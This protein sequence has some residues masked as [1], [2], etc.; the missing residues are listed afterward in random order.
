MKPPDVIFES[1]QRGTVSERRIVTLEN[2]G[3]G[4][5]TINDFE[6]TGTGAAHFAIDNDLLDR[7]CAEDETLSAS[8]SCL[9]GV[10]FTPSDAGARQAELTFTTNDPATPSAS[11]TLHGIAT[12]PPP[13]TPPPPASATP[14]GDTDGDGVMDSVDSCPGVPGVLSNGCP[15]DRDGD[16]IVDS[17]DACLTVAGSL[18]NG[19]PR[20]SDGDDVLDNEDRCI[21]VAGNLKNGCPN[22]L[23]ADVAGRWRVNSLRSQ[24]LSLTVRASTGSR[25]E[26]LCGKRGGCGFTKRTTL[27]T[28]K[29]VTGLTRHFKGRR[30]L[31]AGV[32][33]IV[34]VTRP[35]QSGTYESLQTRTGRKLP[36]VTERCLAAGTTDTITRCS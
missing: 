11:A 29:G 33:I 6:I 26:L 3:A 9:V 23:N 30:I 18:R 2:E 7:A 19:C 32:S 4:E 22:E 15:L 17:A 5:L 31:R 12:A 1:Q 36:R 25:I 20:D 34:R 14:P 13:P 35:Q 24:L 8:S 28:T 16:G 27:R 10:R 21:S